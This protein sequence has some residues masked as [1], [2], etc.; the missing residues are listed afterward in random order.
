MISVVNTTCSIGCNGVAAVRTKAA[1]TFLGWMIE[2][3]RPIDQFRIRSF[4]AAPASAMTATSLIVPHPR[5]L[6]EASCCHNSGR[7]SHCACRHPCVDLNHFAPPWVL[8]CCVIVTAE[9]SRQ[10]SSSCLDDGGGDDAVLM[11][12]NHCQYIPDSIAGL[13]RA[14]MG[15]PESNVDASRKMS[16]VPLE[17]VAFAMHTLSWNISGTAAKPHRLGHPEAHGDQRAETLGAQTETKPQ[18]P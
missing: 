2:D 14:V 13:A 1:T 16:H 4:S 7:S 8:D 10:R 12:S 15:V 3:V 6:R 5:A 17:G 9:A 11:V 18:C